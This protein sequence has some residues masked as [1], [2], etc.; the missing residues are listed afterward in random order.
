MSIF[1]AV[2]AVAVFLACTSE[3]LPPV[4]AT[5]DGVAIKGYDPVAYFTLGEPAKGS[6]EFEYAWQGAKWRFANAEHLGLFKA[7]PGKYAPQYEGY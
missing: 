6:Q 7:D 2:A 3:A 1:I 4:N 5:A